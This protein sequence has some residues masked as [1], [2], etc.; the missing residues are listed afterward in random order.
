[1]NR[2]PYCIRMS[3]PNTF[4][5]RGRHQ[6]KRQKAIAEIEGGKITGQSAWRFRDCRRR[7]NYTW[8]GDCEDEKESLGKQHT[9]KFDS[10]C[11]FFCLHYL[12]TG[13]TSFVRL[14]T[15]PFV[16]LDFC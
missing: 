6:Y 5:A 15:P 1:M 10:R 16:T 8:Q 13:A 14:I 12:D 4:Y 3:E 7:T 2:A 11:S 9:N